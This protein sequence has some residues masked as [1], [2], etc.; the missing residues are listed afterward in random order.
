M[1]IVC[2][3]SGKGEGVISISPMWGYEIF[4]GTTQYTDILVNA[5]SYFAGPNSAVQG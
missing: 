2:R 5:F 4:S 1:L 3:M